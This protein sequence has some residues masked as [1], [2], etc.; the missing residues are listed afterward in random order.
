[1]DFM[2]IRD[3]VA[4]CERRT[5]YSRAPAGTPLLGGRRD[6]YNGGRRS[7]HRPLLMLRQTRESYA[8][9]IREVLK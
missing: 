7:H 9:G 1:M 8:V 4:L 3:Q 6:A 2:S 5:R